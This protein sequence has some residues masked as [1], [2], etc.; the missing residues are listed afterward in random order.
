MSTEPKPDYGQ[1]PYDLSHNELWNIACDLMDQ[2]D[3]LL[4]TLKNA[5]AETRPK[6]EGILGNEGYFQVDIWPEWAAQA[7]DVVAKVEAAEFRK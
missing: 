3:A 1:P 4:V 2:R 6:R 7:I 5:I